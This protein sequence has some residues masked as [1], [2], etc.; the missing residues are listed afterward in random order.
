MTN[1]KTAHKY[2]ELAIKSGELT[3]LTKCEACGKTPTDNKTKSI[4]AH[5][6][7]GYDEYLNVWWVCR[8]CNGFLDIHDGSLLRDN[9][10]EYVRRKQYERAGYVYEPCCKEVNNL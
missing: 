9:A 5:H 10:K 2:V 3:R 1:Q 4:V 7:N 8:S 6:W